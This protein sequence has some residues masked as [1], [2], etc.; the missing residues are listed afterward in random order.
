MIRNKNLLA[1]IS[2]VIIFL[3]VLVYASESVADSESIVHRMANFVIQISLIL[4]AARFSGIL[5]KKM[6]LPSVLGELV[7]GIILGPS[8]L[9]SIPLPLFFENGI[10]PQIEGSALPVQPELYAIATI[11][12]IVLLFLAGLETDLRL[13]AQFSFAGFVVGFGGVIFSFVIGLFTAAIWFHIPF[14]DPRALLLGV[15]STATSV[16]ITIRVLS[17]KRKVGTPEGITIL[18]GAVVDDILGIILFSVIL[19]IASLNKSFDDQSNQIIKVW[20]LIFKALAVWIG[21]TVLGLMLSYRISAILKTF[22]SI[23]VITASA[24]G[25]ALLLS[26]IFEKAGLAM[27]IGAYIMGMTLSKTD[28]SH[29]IMDTLHP[30]QEFFVPVFFV[31]MGMMVNIKEILAPSVL[32]F[33]LIFTIGAI[34]A[35]VIGCG[36]P[37][38]GLKFNTLGA[39]RIGIG[40]VPRGEVA[41]IVA[42]IGLSSGFLNQ[43]L[44]GAAIMMTLITT[45][46]APP[47]LNFI[48]TNEKGSLREPEKGEL[49][50][51]VFDMSSPYLVEL[52]S[53][54]LVQSFI[55]EGFYVNTIEDEIKICHIRRNRTSITLYVESKVLRFESSAHDTVF[56]KNVVYEN[57]VRLN[58]M[59][60]QI[61]GLIKP[62]E[63]KPRLI[64]GEISLDFDVRKVLTS[65]C[66]C[67]NLNSNSKVDILRELIEI[68]YN[69]KQISDPQAVLDAVLDREN[70]LSTGMQNGIA[71][72]HGKTD[73]VD[74]LVVAIGIHRKGVDFQSLDGQHSQIFICAVAPR[75]FSGPH[76]RFIAYVGALLNTK[77]KVKD[78]LACNNPEEVYHFFTGDK[79]NK[80]LPE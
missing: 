5:F 17:D 67:T 61:K 45:I 73:S 44:F 49:I 3:P 18:A 79:R 25:L 78:L 36:I 15:I 42:G 2:E 10:F 43:Q 41:L 7:A 50:E 21:F 6:K 38:I 34:I 77:E 28:L 51:T 14:S 37:A 40:M 30:I 12:S 53:E 8:I 64:D 48:M 11:G 76:I 16:G 26:G 74:R 46:I 33:G 75:K 70:S 27:I 13:F 71:L 57:L 65:N 68:L 60:N 4:F 59:I 32:T 66:I 20:M 52:L 62:D 1:L 47:I 80:K 69:N 55:S 22:K 31:V 63:M 19:G 24:L 72:P 39:L 58:D 29:V 9:G 35:K 54:R 23:S 56:V